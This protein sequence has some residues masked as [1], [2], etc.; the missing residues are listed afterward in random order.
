MRS[1]KAPQSV[2]KF[3]KLLFLSIL[4][5]LKVIP[6]EYR[7][8]HG[9]KKIPKWFLVPEM[10]LKLFAGIQKPTKLLER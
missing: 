10:I 1:F 3:L 6:K 9:A 2:F 7:H 4:R 5:F 8:F